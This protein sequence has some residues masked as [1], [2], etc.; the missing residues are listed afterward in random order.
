MEPVFINKLKQTKEHYIEMNKKHSAFTI[1]FLGAFFLIAYL[2][3]AVY[4][5]FTLYNIIFSVAV[6][7]IGILLSAYPHIRIYIIARNREKQL[8]E[9]LNEIPE[10]ETMFF[11]DHL[12]SV[13]TNNAELKLEYGKIK[14][15][16]QSKNLYLLVLKKKLVVMVDK[17]RFEKGTCEEFEKFIAEK[18][19]NAK[20]KL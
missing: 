19:V 16:K 8:L 14:K 11:E 4:I 18:A 2:G 17:N 13:S 9:L 1:Y 7:L 5:Y 6:A 20:I 12:M 10:S 15:V 3:L